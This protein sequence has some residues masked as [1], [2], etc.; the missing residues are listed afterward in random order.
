MRFVSLSS[1]LVV[2]AFLVG[3][4]A[5]AAVSSQVITFTAVQVSEK[6]PSDTSFII[7]DNDLVNGKKVGTDTLS[8]SIVSQTK[9]N[10][11]I[12]IARKDG[13]IKASFVLPFTASKGA[14]TITGG[15][16][17]YAGAKGTFSYKNL[18]DEGTRTSVVLKLG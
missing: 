3:A 13:T 6:H 10:C 8:C 1:A 4:A 18:N 12:V 14:G 15:T 2:G 7:K 17:A 9:A 5:Q 11:K 16:G